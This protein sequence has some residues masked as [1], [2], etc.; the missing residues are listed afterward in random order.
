[1][2]NDA[3][4]NRLTIYMVKSEFGRPED[5]LKNFNQ[6]IPIDGVGSFYTEP[7]HSNRAPWLGRFFG[8]ALGDI[9]DVFTASARGIFLVPI[10][11][12]DKVVH[13]ALSFGI[14]HHMLNDEALE[15]RFGLRVVLNSA[16][17]SKIRSIEKTNLGA[18][19]KHSREQMG[20]DVPQTDFGI[21]VEQDLVGSVS[22]KSRDQRLGKTISGKHALHVSVPVNVDN[23][24]DFL[25]YCLSRYR[26]EE[27]KTDFDWMDQIV[28]TDK[29][30][31]APLNA[32]LVE[33]INGGNLD[34]IWMAVPEVVDWATISGFRYRHRDRGDLFDDL[35][36][37]TFVADVGGEP[38]S[39]DTLRDNRIFAISAIDDRVLES[40]SAYR[41]TYAELELE[42]NVF[43]LNNGAWYKIAK[44][45]TTAVQRDFANIPDATIEM[46]N[47]VSGDELA[48][49]RV[50]VARMGDA[51]CMDRDLIPH[52]GAHNKIEFCD[53]FTRSRNMIHVKKYG[54]SSVLSHLFAQGVVSA[55]TFASDPDF[56]R[57]LNAKLPEEYRLRDPVEAPD[58]SQYEV[59]YAIISK[60]GDPLEIPF[61]SK[62]S[63]R[64][65]YRTL[66]TIG[67][68]ASKKKIQKVEEGA[69]GD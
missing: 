3:R 47:Y 37:L 16:D 48:Y 68:A 41:C 42:D 39:I 9:R 31:A 61:F 38:I 7:S 32:E 40:W 1:M 29:T 36:M 17:P 65:A 4:T 6:P 49:N 63:I 26:S 43:I 59:V 50:A 18:V 57:K 53:I 51:V 67:Y 22:A 33:R 28:P 69:A 23:V 5:I 2:P 15:Q 56:R 58:K 44:D 25:F 21:D 62:V 45:F 35:D 55:E 8:D 12:G 13:F 11:E 64:N 14:G 19:P 34:K 10:A 20:R 52:G 60:G 27:Y 24:A 30:T 66:R 46:P 54:G